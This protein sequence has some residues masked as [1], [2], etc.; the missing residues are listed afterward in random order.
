MVIKGLMF[1]LKSGSKYKKNV[2]IK[3]SKWPVFNGTIMLH[4]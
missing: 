2:L 3:M 4:I 1:F